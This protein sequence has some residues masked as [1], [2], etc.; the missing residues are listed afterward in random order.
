[1]KAYQADIAKFE[2]SGAKVFGISTDT[3]EINTKFHKELGLTFPLLSDTDNTASKN[4]GI[5]NEK[6]K[7]AMRATFV[8]DKKGVITYIEEGGA[9]ISTEGA[10]KACS[11]FAG[12]MKKKEN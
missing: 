1:M 7:M 4:Y 6:S 10:I 3:L 2:A 12:V 5:L 11:V 9:A 8:I